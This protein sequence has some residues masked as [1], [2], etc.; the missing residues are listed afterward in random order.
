MGMLD[1]VGLMAGS[2]GIVSWQSGT[3]DVYS[4]TDQLQAAQHACNNIVYYPYSQVQPIS[5]KR[6]IE[7]L[8]DEVKD[9]H[10][11]VLGRKV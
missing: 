3:N 6:A 7:K 2:Q 11:N 9:W 4:I 10:G 8:R 5:P 1:A